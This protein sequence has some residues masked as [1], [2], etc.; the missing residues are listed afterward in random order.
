MEPESSS[1]HS[2][3]PATCPYP[4]AERSSPCIH[5][6]FIENKFYY[7]PPIY[8]KVFHVVSFHLVSSLLRP[9]EMF[10]GTITFYG[11]ELLAP[12]PTSKLEDNPF[13]AV[14]GYL[15]RIPS[16]SAGRSSA[17]NMWTR[18]DVVTRTH[19]SRKL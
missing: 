8:M 9:C 10:C 11:K 1:P 4:Q 7:Y 3:A 2:K 5:I 12:R 16:I 6:L 14:H 13:S 15:F 17:R 19:L 18:H